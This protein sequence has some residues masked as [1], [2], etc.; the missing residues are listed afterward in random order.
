MTHNQNIHRSRIFFGRLVATLLRGDRYFPEK[1]WSKG[2]H[3]YNFFRLYEQIFGRRVGIR[4]E[5]DA[6]SFPDEN[7][8]WVVKRRFYTLEARFCWYEAV[9]REWAKRLVTGFAVNRFVYIHQ[10]SFGA[11]ARDAFTNAF[12]SGGTLSF[13]VTGTTPALF[14]GTLGDSGADNQ[15]GTTYNSVSMGKT[16]AYTTV[17]RAGVGWYLSGTGD[18]SAHN[19]VT[20]GGAYCEQYAQSFSGCSNTGTTPD[21][22]NVGSAVAGT[23]VTATTTVVASNCWLAAYAKSPGTATTYTAGSG[24]SQRYAATNEGTCDSNGTVGTGSQSLIENGG[25]DSYGMVIVSIAPFTASGPS[26][27]KSFD[28]NVKS[29]IKSYN[30]NLIANIKSIDTNA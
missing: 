16:D 2:S 9:V 1:K 15:T 25:V 14:L 20:S 27:L 4:R 5:A 21:S 10:P 23:S 18:G 28:T 24:T 8:K 3:V 26:N 11:I 17:G 22:H 7:G 29:N 13:T 12:N 6:S 30:T 19:I